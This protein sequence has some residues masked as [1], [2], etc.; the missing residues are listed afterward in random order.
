MDGNWIFRNV[1]PLYLDILALKIFHSKS[2]YFQ[3]LFKPVFPA[4]VGLGGL[5]EEGS[6]GTIG[7]VK[8]PV[9]GPVRSPGVGGPQRLGPSRSPTGSQI[10]A[11]QLHKI[12]RGWTHWDPPRGSH[13]FECRLLR[14]RRV[15]SPSC[16]ATWLDR[17]E[18]PLVSP[19]KIS[20]SSKLSPPSCS[21]TRRSVTWIGGRKL[22]S[23]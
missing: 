11:I 14:L 23:K 4:T 13:I 12:F 7:F 10:S 8:G 16:E 21:S 18:I 9:K 22:F 2:N 20:R 15:N 5:C 1:K 19:R 17:V 6:R 3:Y